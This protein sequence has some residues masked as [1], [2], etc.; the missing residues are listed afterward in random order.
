MRAGQRAVVHS[1]KRAQL[2][3]IAVGSGGGGSVGGVV[4]RLSAG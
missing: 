4:V 3:L 2:L 1:R